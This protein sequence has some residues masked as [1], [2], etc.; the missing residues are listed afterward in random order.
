MKAVKNTYSNKKR[1]IRHA[2]VRRAYSSPVLIPHATPKVKFLFAISALGFA[3]MLSASLNYKSYMQLQ[4]EKNETKL[5]E[6]QVREKVDQNLELQEEI[7]YLK[8]DKET[9][10]REARRYGLA[11]KN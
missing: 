6:E 11:P 4:S 3:I 2:R 1:P 7:L 10:E 5:L 8:T 9:I